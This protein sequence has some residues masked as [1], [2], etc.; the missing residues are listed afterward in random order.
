MASMWPRSDDRGKGCCDVIW[1]RST[2]ASMWPRSD[3]RGK[4]FVSHRKWGRRALQCGRGQMTAESR[5]NVAAAIPA[6]L[7]SMW[8]RS[9]DRGKSLFP[10]RALALVDRASMW[11]RSDDRGKASK[12]STTTIRRSRFNVAAVR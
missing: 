12:A 4:A 5:I 6:V 11:P 1:L 3:D 7:A 9:D 2:G 10:L 8:P